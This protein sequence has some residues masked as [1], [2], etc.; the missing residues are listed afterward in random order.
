M[1][2]IRRWYLLLV[3]AISMP[4]VTWSIIT[5][6]RGLLIPSMG[7]DAEL[8]SFQIAMIIIGMPI[9]L[10]HWRWARGSESAREEKGEPGPLPQP[11][12]L[13][14][15]LA[16]FIAPLAANTF[17][18][19]FHLLRLAL[20]TRSSTPLYG[21]STTE[22]VI[23]SM[24]AIGVLSLLVIYFFNLLSKSHAE[25]LITDYAAAVRR[26]FLLGL[27]AAGLIMTIT[28]IIIVNIMILC[29]CYYHH[30]HH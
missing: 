26:L 22:T 9:F 10:F 17:H 29:C 8:F 12:Y 30:Q 21:L 7:A 14:G 13:H 3:C 25:V 27:S 24:L 5:L 16:C 20:N 2:N 19:I 18:L 23:H 28:G 4:A 6:L 11:L 15:M 1:T